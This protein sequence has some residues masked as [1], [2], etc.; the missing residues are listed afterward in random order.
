MQLVAV[1]IKKP[2]MDEESPYPYLR[3][4]LPKCRADYHALR[5]C[6]D[7]RQDGQGR[8]DLHTLQSVDV[9][10]VFGAIVSPQDLHC[11]FVDHT[12]HPHDEVRTY[13]QP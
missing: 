6:R 7:A 12:Q 9:M 5:K 11:E 10:H 2:H 4:W 1:K 8:L 3:E 13:Q